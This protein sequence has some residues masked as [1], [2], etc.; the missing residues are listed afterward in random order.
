MHRH[1]RDLD[2]LAVQAGKKRA[3]GTDAAVAR[4]L[5]RQG[6]LVPRSSAQDRARRGQ[7]C[8][9]SEPQLQVAAR[10]QPLQLL[11]RALGDQHA[12][13][14]QRD[15]VGELVCFLQVLRG[16]EDRD[17]AGDQV[18]DDLPHRLPAARVKAGGRL[19]EEDDAGVAHER[20]GQ[21]QP[22]SHPAR[23]RGG[24]RPGGVHEVEPLEQLSG[25][26]A[27]FG[28]V[29]VPQVGHE[30]Q[31]LLA[32][33]QLVHGRVLAGDTDR[34]PDR[35]GFAYQVVAGH[36]HHAA[37]GGD[38]RG[39]DLHDRRLACAVRAEQRE[40]RAGVDVQVDAV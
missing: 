12:V 13:I 31:V 40:D 23:V 17:A 4:N 35:V 38:Q 20:H 21:V 22:A 6:L 1:L 27:A 28:P 33:Q 2:R 3:D 25:A 26:P 39:Q 11:G 5:Q 18:A 14:E 15:T 30:Q 10:N 32:G 24:H 19:V 29:Q 8:R 16:E 36:P 7:S 34:G 9:V 37:V